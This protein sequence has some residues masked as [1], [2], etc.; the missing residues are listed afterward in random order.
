[1]GDRIRSFEWDRTPI[2]APQGWC[3]SLQLSLDICLHSSFPTAIYWGPDL[4]LLYNDSWAPVAGRR[5]PAALGRPAQ[6]VWPDI[7][8]IIEPQ[9]REV[10]GTGQ[11]YSTSDQ[12]L[13][14]TRLGYLEESYWDYSFTPITGDDGSIA[15]I[16]NQGHEVTERVVERQRSAL[17]LGLADRIRNLDHPDAIV[18]EALEAVGT[19]LGGSRVGYAEI[20]VAANTFRITHNWLRDRDVVDLRATHPIGRFGKDLHA[21]LLAGKIFNMQDALTDPRIARGPTS[22]IYAAIG[23]RAGLV[24]PVLK[25]G[26]YTAALFL[27]DDKPRYWQTHHEVLLAG[28]AE[29][30]WQDVV[31]VNAGRALRESEQRHRLIFEQANDIIFTADLDQRLTAVNPAAG[32]AL[33]AAPESLIG[34]PIADFLTEDDFGRT[35]QMLR[36][37]LINGGTTRYDVA[38]H[39]GNGEE[40]FWE[41]SSTLST[42]DV[43]QPIGLHAI[44]RD[45]TERHSHEQ[46]Q[47]RLISELNHR[48]KNMLALVQGLAL[49][50]FKGERPVAEAQRAFQARLGALASAHDLLTREKWAGA[51][52]DEIVAAATRA[53]A[54]APGHVTCDGPV[55][56]LEPKVAVSL[57]MAFHEL[58]ANAGHYGALSVDGG[59]LAIH[60]H[61]QGDRLLIEWRE[62]GGPPVE[63]PLQRGFGLRMVE[64]SLA[65]DLSARVEFSFPD[66][67]FRCAINAPNLM[68]AARATI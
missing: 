49:Q 33:G 23:V 3:R 35:S 11:G 46:S 37:K 19:H 36:E 59:R 22:E 45:V 27:H 51:T 43:G 26:I 20:D 4:R 64:R 56:A 54:K 9:F 41:V 52:L 24:V 40:L 5:H 15:G 8:H 50:S 30:I 14:M 2:G 39:P 13:P 58:A 63:A 34:R 29:R 47:R 32:R 28:V 55:I 67:G 6:A 31:R 21:A 68:P 16:L 12:H 38:V 65:T 1:M 61:I 44:A 25:D 66:T 62:S 53:Y 48:V 42:D 18:Q 57:V 17:L 10:I 60:W 7:W